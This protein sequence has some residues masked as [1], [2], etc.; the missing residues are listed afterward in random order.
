MGNISIKN[1]LLGAGVAIIFSIITW[2]LGIGYYIVLGFILGFFVIVYFMYRTGKEARDL[3]GGFIEFGQIFK[4]L[5]LTFM[6]LSFITSIFQY[7][8][9]NF[10]DTNLMANMND[11]I[12]DFS[13]SRMPAEAAEEARDQ[14]EE[15]FAEAPTTLELLPA[16]WGWVKGLILGAII[17]A[18]MS[19]IMKKKN[20]AFNEFA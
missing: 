19:A 2:F 9:V 1:G 4:Y 3:N 12:K 13:L 16:L 6:I 5:M 15:K 7:I 11:A 14:L 20:P 8:M 10:I 18:I 17:A